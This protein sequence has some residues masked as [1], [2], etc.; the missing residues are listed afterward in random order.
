MTNGI[1]TAFFPGRTD[2]A[3]VLMLHGTGGDESDLLPIATFLFPE[4]PKL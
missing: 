2:L 1:H 4:H 3:P